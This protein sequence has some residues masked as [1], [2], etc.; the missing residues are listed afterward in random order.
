MGNEGGGHD[1]SPH[2]RALCASDG[3]CSSRSLCSRRRPRRRAGG[4]DAR[5]QRDTPDCS[6]P[7]RSEGRKGSGRRGRSASTPALDLEQRSRRA[8]APTSSRDRSPRLT[9]RR[10]PRRA[11]DLRDPRAIEAKP[12]LR[13]VAEADDAELG[14]VLIDPASLAAEDAG[15]LAG[16]EELRPLGPRF[17]GE[18]ARDL[19]RDALRESQ[20]GR[21]K[22]RLAGGRHRV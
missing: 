7:R 15:D 9:W 20:L 1:S 5:P 22:T 21:R 6:R 12:R 11:R 14:L 4:A 18:A 8:S 13:A 19:G 3:P 16:V 2:L 17:A 10:D